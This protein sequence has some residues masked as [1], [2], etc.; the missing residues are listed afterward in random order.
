MQQRI[1][2]VAHSISSAVVLLLS[3]ATASAQSVPVR[4]EHQVIVQ[5]TAPATAGQAIELYV[6]EVSSSAPTE[7]IPV[8]F[9][10]G[11]G[12]PAEVAFD[13]PVAGY[14]WM[15][16]LA[17][18][19]FAT[20]A[21]DMTGYGRSQR[22]APMADRCNLS[23]EQ[24]KQEFGDACAATVATA[25]TTM[26]SDWHDIDE[27]V[28]FLRA[29]HG[30][31]QVK[32]VGWSQG[33]P[34]TL[35]YAHGH[36]DKVASVVVLAPAYNRNAAATAADAPIAGTAITKQSQQDFLT[37][38]NGQ[39]PCMNQYDPVVA[40]AVWNE[41]LASDPIG[42]TWGSGVRRAPRVPTFGWTPT[43]VAATTVPV[44][45]AAGLTDGQVRP[46]R[47]R[48][49]YADIGSSSKVLAELECASHNAMWEHG[50]ERLFDA[51]YQWLHDTTYDGKTSG[52]FVLKSAK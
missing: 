40:T 10:H 33:G 45:L 46:D 9:V 14:S 22:P 8:L 42:A 49:L 47:V 51:S 44:L 7:A 4:H 5:S 18:R 2:S 21:T 32:L 41:M 38:W 6:R 24:Q 23:E 48:E 35:G 30:V 50:A 17:E 16:Y 52:T 36:A 12:T 28:D 25:L 31:D 34:R 26:E 27:V 19:G 1:K 13:V 15:A 29:K 3:A 37:Q 11:A 20:Y 43:E 39:A